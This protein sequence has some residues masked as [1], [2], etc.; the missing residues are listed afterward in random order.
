MRSSRSAEGLRRR[1][2]RRAAR[3]PSEGRAFE[4]VARCPAGPIRGREGPERL[5]SLLGRAP[6]A[7]VLCL[8]MRVLTEQTVRVAEQWLDA[9]GYGAVIKEHSLMGGHAEGASD[10][11]DSPEQDAVVVGTLD[12]LLS[13]AI[14]RGYGQSR[15][16]WP[17]DFALFNQRVPLGARRGPA[18]GPCARDQPPAGRTSPPARHGAADLVHVDVG[19]RV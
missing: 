18:D 1:P 5:W 15:Y 4:R 17:I 6:E 8:P 7:T 19:D 12:M 11:H 10:L 13:R 2:A 16:A 14:N 3:L 9:T